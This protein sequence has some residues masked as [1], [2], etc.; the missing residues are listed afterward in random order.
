M[1]YGDFVYAINGVSFHIDQ[2]ECYGLVGESG[3]GKTTIAR[4]IAGVYPIDHGTITIDG[5]LQR[6]LFSRDRSVQYIFQDPAKSL[7]PRLSVLANISGG[8]RYQHKGI[9]KQEIYRRSVGA[10]E[11][12]GMSKSDL[13]RKPN[14]FSGG[15]RQRI[16]IAR[17][18]IYSPKLLIC[19]EIVS[20][21]DVSIRAQIIN[22]L[23]DLRKQYRLSM[24]FISHDLALVS[25]FCDRIG[26]LYR[27]V[28]VE[29]ARS[30]DLLKKR[31]HPYTERLFHAIPNLNNRF[32]PGNRVSASAVS[33]GEQ[34]PTAILTGERSTTEKPSNWDERIPVQHRHVVRYH[35]VVIDFP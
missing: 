20:A 31:Y 17:A 25:Y 16:A 26:V 24:L 21:L 3:S 2:N 27:G 30:A 11:S 13:A 9:D 5:V 14:E 32:A 23:L 7:N 1:R 12:V 6:K 28:I 35:R 15:Q 8:M 29:E 22:L 10:I 34:R 33:Q 19:D 18:L 4:C